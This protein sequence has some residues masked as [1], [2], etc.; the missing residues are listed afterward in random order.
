MNNQNIREISEALMSASL[1]IEPAAVNDAAKRV[2]AY[3]E[4]ASRNVSLPEEEVADRFSELWSLWRESDD[5]RAGTE[6]KA[7]VREAVSV[8][9]N[10]AGIAADYFRL[11]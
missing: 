3:Y 6:L 5:G 10:M 7:V 1:P 2:A 8:D 11:C 9:E 4:G